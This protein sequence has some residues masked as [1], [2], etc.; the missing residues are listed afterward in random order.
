MRY[1]VVGLALMVVG[2]GKEDRPADDLAAELIA[3]RPIP[4]FR[5][6]PRIRCDFQFRQV[7]NAAQRCE[8]VDPD[9]VPTHIM[10]DR[11]EKE[12]Q[13]CV[14]GECDMHQIHAIETS[15]AFENVILGNGMMVKIGDYGRFVDIATQMDSVFISSGTCRAL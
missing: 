15:G 3:M 14:N 11:R 2:C 7:C 1:L 13:R 8:T 9:N 6:A 12:Y 4:G 10:V 5:E